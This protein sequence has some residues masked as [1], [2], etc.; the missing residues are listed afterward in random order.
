MRQPKPSPTLSSLIKEMQK[1][2]ETQKQILESLRALEEKTISPVLIP[3][4]IYPYN[5]PLQPPWISP[6]WSKY[7]T[8]T[9]NARNEH[10]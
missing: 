9:D 5:P 2:Q 7:G 10:G 6:V 8:G 3:Y 4:P 1:I